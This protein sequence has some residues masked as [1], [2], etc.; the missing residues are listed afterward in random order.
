MWG[1]GVN[2]FATFLQEGEIMKAEMSKRTLEQLVNWSDD[3]SVDW[4]VL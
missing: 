2:N 4:S 3:A 1:L